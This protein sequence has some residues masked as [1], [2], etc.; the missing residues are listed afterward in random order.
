MSD[1][2]AIDCTKVALESYKSGFRFHQHHTN[3]DM[4][5]LGIAVNWPHQSEI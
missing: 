3:S 2:G 1:I 4:G 5:S